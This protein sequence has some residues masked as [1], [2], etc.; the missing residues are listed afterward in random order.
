MSHS[1]KNQEWQKPELAE[2]K[3]E[4]SAQTDGEAEAKAKLETGSG[5]PSWT[6]KIE[7]KIIH[8]S[9]FFN[10][11][12]PIVICDSHRLYH[13]RSANL[14]RNAGSLKSCVAWR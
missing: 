13:L 6:F 10:E 5:V 8:V 14:P 9:D 3:V 1:V 7:G 11:V 4:D 12:R 2:P